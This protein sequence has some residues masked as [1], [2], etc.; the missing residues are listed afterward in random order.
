MKNVL[1]VDVYG[2]AIRFDKLD[3]MLEKNAF[4]GPGGTD[5]GEGFVGLD[6]QIDIF[7]DVVSIEGLV[8][9]AETHFDPLRFFIP[10]LAAARIGTLVI[11]AAQYFLQERT[12][13]DAPDG[14][15]LIT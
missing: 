10:D 1:T 4:P 9:A 5:N 11:A 12:Q 14:A 15:P 13:N 8:E 7:E 2:T 3:D 6:S